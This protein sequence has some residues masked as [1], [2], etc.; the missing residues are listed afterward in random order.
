MKMVE[1][2]SSS[3]VSVGYSAGNKSMDI[4]F[5]SG[6]Y[7]YENVPPVIYDEMLKAESVGKFVAKNVKGY[8]HYMIVPKE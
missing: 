4:Q 1:V 2:K 5:K 7:R 6:L 8:F 3:V